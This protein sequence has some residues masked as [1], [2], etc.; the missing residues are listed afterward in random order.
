MIH[1][2]SPLT[3]AGL[4]NL[5]RHLMSEAPHRLQEAGGII[6]LL[7]LDEITE[8]DKLH[9][10][11]RLLIKGDVETARTITNMIGTEFF[12]RQ[13]ASISKGELARLMPILVLAGNSGGNERVL[14]RAIEM[15]FSMSEIAASIL[16][17]A[18]DM[19]LKGR[20][21][22]AQAL[23]NAIEWHTIE[24]PE[25]LSA[26]GMTYNRLGCFDTA[27][28]IFSFAEGQGLCCPK[29]YTNKAIVHICLSQF[30]QAENC[31]NLDIEKYGVGFLNL[32]W[33]IRLKNIFQ[34]TEE[35]LKIANTL[36]DAHDLSINEKCMAL[37]EKGI[38]YRALG[39]FNESTDCFAE[40][41]KIRASFPMWRCI[42]C[43]EI[44]INMKLS[45]SDE[46][47][48]T[49]AM[50]GHRIKLQED[51]VKYNPCTILCQYLERKLGKP[52]L[53]PMPLDEMEKFSQLWPRPYFP[54]QVWMRTLKGLAKNIEMN[55]ND[56]NSS[57]ENLAI[58]LSS[59]YQ[60]NYIQ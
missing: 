53:L 38:S 26:L 30:E 21:M 12:K 9:A 6:A 37:I 40:A 27:E 50:S 14:T 34:E 41:E 13:I 42:A 19:L 17:L 59:C 47:A 44:G 36:I 33:K 57:I 11:E 60:S 51:Y 25:Q 8:Q 45:K 55:S 1:F 48:L 39:Y 16:P 4:F 20:K 3:T 24:M 22:E 43:F 46:D 32:F 2:S 52:T 15:R 31:N 54:Y 7:T 35:A 28:E 18:N 58:R 5:A 56:N 23:M 29:L 49:A 10:L